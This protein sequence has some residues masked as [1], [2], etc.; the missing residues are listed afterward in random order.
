MAIGSRGGG[1][2]GGESESARRF[3]G[4]GGG[5]RQREVREAVTGALSLSHNICGLVAGNRRDAVGVGLGVVIF[6][7]FFLY[8]R[9]QL[10]LREF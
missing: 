10:V 3:C 1:G 9:G 7:F 2:G 6:P 8:S 4:G 5:D